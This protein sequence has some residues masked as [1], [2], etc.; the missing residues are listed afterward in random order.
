[1]KFFIWVNLLM[2]EDCDKV[3]VSLVRAKF[4]L[5]ADE[6]DIPRETKQFASTILFLIAESAKLTKVADARDVIMDAIHET[7]IKHFGVI[8]TAPVESAWKRTNIDM[9]KAVEE[10]KE[11]LLKS[12]H[13]RLVPNEPAKPAE[14]PDEPA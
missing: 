8:V 14:I 1:M 4:H 3:I 5:S 12:V 7:G 2:A 6:R 13:L 9:A 10:R 11:K